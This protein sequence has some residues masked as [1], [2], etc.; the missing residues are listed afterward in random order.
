MV[1]IG[2]NGAGKSSLLKIIAGLAKPDDGLIT[3]Q[4]ELTTVY[5]P[6]EPE[7]DL[8]AS[9]FDVVASGLSH[10]QELL[11]EYDQ[12]AH[13]L[14]DAPEG[15]EHDALMARMNS[16]Q[17]SLDLTDAWNWQTRVATTLQQI[18]L[19]GDVRSGA[20]SGGMKKRV[21]LARAL[22]VQPDVLLLDEPTNHLDFEGIRWLEEL[23]VTLR[24]GLLF[25]THDR[26]FLDKVATRIVDLDRGRLLSYP[27]N[28]SAYQTRKA[29]QLEVE[30]VEAA[31]FDKLLAQEEV[32]IRKGRRR[33]GARAASG[34]SRDW[35]KCAM[36]GRNGAMCRAM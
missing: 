17:S 15:A 8:E 27:G 23:L 5:V 10:A 33:R 13:K 3:R 19:D 7:F 36:S 22:V 28:Y 6:Q 34:G 30:Q 26:A 35:S 9:V 24:T 11:D 1:L 2:R 20:L 25:I 31:K 21:A 32:W 14:A 18:G 4:N 29:Q 16:L 12:V